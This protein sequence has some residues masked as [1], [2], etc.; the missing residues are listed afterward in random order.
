MAILIIKFVEK[1]KWREL[2]KE[3]KNGYVVLPKNMGFYVGCGRK[4]K[5]P[6]AYPNP[7]NPNNFVHKNVINQLNK[8]NSK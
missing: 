2:S 8:M 7:E 1:R 6:N 3:L 4:I 5:S